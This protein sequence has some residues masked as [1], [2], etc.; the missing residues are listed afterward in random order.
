MSRR[1]RRRSLSLVVLLAIL[2]AAL[3]LA[4][5]TESERRTLRLETEQ[6]RPEPP[7]FDSC[8]GLFYQ[9]CIDRMVTDA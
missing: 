8:E 2:A 4:R 1:S 9:Q 5:A 3:L 7:P 6:V